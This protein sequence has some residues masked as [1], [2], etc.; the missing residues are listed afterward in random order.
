MVLLMIKV[1]SHFYLQNLA[2]ATDEGD[3]A[4]FTD[5]VKEFDSMTP[6]VC[7]QVYSDLAVWLLAVECC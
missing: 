7:S 5:I 1:Y 2:S 6:L 4:K 3:I